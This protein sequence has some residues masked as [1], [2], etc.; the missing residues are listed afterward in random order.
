MK[1]NSKRSGMGSVAVLAFVFTIAVLGVV[2]VSGS[3]SAYRN[4]SRT[5]EK[6][7]ANMLAQA[8]LE[9]MYNRIRTQMAASGDYPFTIAST[10][11]G[12]DGNALKPAGS[13]SAKVVTFQ[14]AQLDHDYYGTRLRRTDY[15]FEIEATGVARYGIKS[16]I[17]ARFSAVREQQLKKIT[18]TT[19]IGQAPKQIYFPRAAMSSAGKITFQNNAGVTI[20]SPNHASGHVLAAQGIVWNPVS[21]SKESFGD[22]KVVD[23]EGQYV[24]NH[25]A[26]EFTKSSNGLGNSNGSKNYASPSPKDGIDPNSVLYTDSGVSL[27]DSSV[28]TSWRDRW[29][30]VASG[31]G[32]VVYNA[33]VNSAAITPDAGGK[34]TLQ[35][36][37]YINGDLL[38][39]SSDT[40]SLYPTSSNPMQNIIYVT[41]DIK[42]LGNIKNLGVKLVSVGKYTE[43]PSSRYEISSAGSPF[44]SDARV[45][46][47]SALM[48]L[49]NDNDAIKLSST[50]T[51]T[52]G[53]VYALNGGIEVSASEKD[54]RG[55]LVS[56]GRGGDSGIKI[57]N[58][59]SGKFKLT[60][61]PEATYPGDI[62]LDSIQHIDVT[63]E[64]DAIWMPFTPSR[65]G[66]YLQLDMNG[67]PVGVARHSNPAPS[68]P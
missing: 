12:Y 33:S 11:V 23:I 52:M 26:F 50:A 38:V 24:V 56:G 17:R 62:D 6:S 28:T 30:P 20:T 35:A 31:T 42:N 47:N 68:T 45:L 32:S 3:M 60:F 58:S 5:A 10:A 9:D 4:T 7:Q 49:S 43:N 57:A 44:T 2:V 8:G 22:T 16:T 51:E 18:T 54:M 55:V 25:D 64:P 36:P 53:L 63:Y 37:A 67:H 46:Q 1:R 14:D 27:A 48:S 59:S 21:G 15:T 40:L 41:G 66:S 39:N 61:T 13:Y 34:R 65:I 19:Q 29:I